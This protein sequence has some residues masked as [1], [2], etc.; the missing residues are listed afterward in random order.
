MVTIYTGVTNDSIVCIIHI[1]FLFI[2]YSLFPKYI[3]DE[4]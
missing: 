1:L 2:Y 3:C 4:V